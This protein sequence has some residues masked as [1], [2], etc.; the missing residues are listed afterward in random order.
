MGF[1]TTLM[2]SELSLSSGQVKASPWNHCICDFHLHGSSL[3]SCIDHPKILLPSQVSTG[4]ILQVLRWGHPGLSYLFYSSEATYRYSLLRR[5]TVAMET[6][7]DGE[8]GVAGGES[9][10]VSAPPQTV[11]LRVTCCTEQ[12]DTAVTIH[13]T[14]NFELTPFFPAPVTGSPGVN[15]RPGCCF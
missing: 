13:I 2:L 11:A 7:D 14:F 15:V 9:D 12:V 10:E 4:H 1:L 5:G 8:A 3:C 6:D